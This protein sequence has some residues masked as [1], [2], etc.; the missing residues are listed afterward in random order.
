MENR[1]VLSCSCKY[2]VIAAVRESN[3]LLRL[4]QNKPERFEVLRAYERFKV[5][6]DGEFGIRNW[7]CLREER[8]HLNV[9]HVI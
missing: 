8:R 1:R 2:G 4:Q 3:L 7:K 9:L 6:K 5:L